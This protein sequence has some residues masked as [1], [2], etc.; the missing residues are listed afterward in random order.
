[1]S[2]TFRTVFAAA[3]FCTALAGQAIWSPVAQPGPSQTSGYAMAYDSARGRTVLFGGSAP[4]SYLAD[5]WEWDGT[6][7]TQVATAGPSPR[8]FGTMAY[9]SLRG[10]TVLFGG[11]SGPVPADDTWEWDGSSWTLVSTGG[12]SPRAGHTMAF[13]SQRGRTV[14]FGGLI[15]SASGGLVFFTD[16]WEW[17]GVAWTQ[18]ATTF[19]GSAGFGGMAYDSAGDRTLL[20]W[21]ADLYAWDG[22]SWTHLAPSP[23]V[24][25]LHGRVVWNPYRRTLVVVESGETWE[26][27][28]A[29][30]W[31][32]YPV[33]P[34]NGPTGVFDGLRNVLVAVTSEPLPVGVHT[35]ELTVTS[36]A[37]AR[38]YGAG[39]GSPTIALAPHVGSRPILG[40]A[41]L[42][43]VTNAFL[44]F[45][46]VV[47]GVTD[48][49]IPLD[50]LGATGCSLW[51]GGEM[52][53]G[54]FCQSTSFSTAQHSLP[55]PHDWSLLG[56]H[57]YLQAWTLAP[58]FNQL[59]VV[60]S[61][62]IELVIG[63]G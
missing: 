7:W 18:R 57:L 53:V 33:G 55:I 37:T 56:V 48:Q 8:Q 35:W 2:M 38:P 31:T 58:N 16:T 4:S 24:N 44:G 30:G 40:Q 60:T 6:S 36:S 52:E 17:D 11:L 39:C 42:S 14:L 46:A 21:N 61:N 59:G 43:D 41:Q 49:S 29:S 5:T 9:D 50:F 27:A 28:A 22:A 63:D 12:P 54:S 34:G 15:R 47:W 26:W 25:G 23:G 10:R 3:S 20:L 13:D 1:M 32:Q 45:A 62:G 19:P 51:N